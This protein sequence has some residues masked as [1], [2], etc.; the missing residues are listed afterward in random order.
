MKPGH[1]YEVGD[2]P[3][4]NLKR[5]QEGAGWANVHECPKCGGN[6]TFCETCCCDH[7]D[8]GWDACQ[9]AA[10]ICVPVK[11]PDCTKGVDYGETCVR[12]GGTAEVDWDDPAHP[13]YRRAASCSTSS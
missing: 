10:F 9:P 8:G 12:C 1:R 2:Q 13:D 7:H 3:C 5:A 11:C 6:R 4:R